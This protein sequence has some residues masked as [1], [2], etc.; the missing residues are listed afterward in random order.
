MQYRSSPAESPTA[1]HSWQKV[2]IYGFRDV[3]GAPLIRHC[4]NA[5]QRARKKTVEVSEPASAPRVDY[6]E[7]PLVTA[8]RNNDLD[9]LNTSE[10]LSRN[11]DYLFNNKEKDSKLEESVGL[12]HVACNEKRVGH[13]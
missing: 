12:L 5:V 13:P 3:I 11:I 8:C 2:F 4:S 9:F 7:N 6:D 1:Q 10:Q